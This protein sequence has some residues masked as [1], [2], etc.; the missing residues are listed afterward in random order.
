MNQDLTNLREGRI[1]SE[2]EWAEVQGMT[3]SELT[4]VMDLERFYKD[5]DDRKREE[6]T[7]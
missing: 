5:V 7:G 4:P 3:H 2:E 6:E 1:M